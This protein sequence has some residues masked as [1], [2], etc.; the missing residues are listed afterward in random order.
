MHRCKYLLS[1]LAALSAST[2]LAQPVP[3]AE[4][5][6]VLDM[7]TI[8]GT[9]LATEVMNSP[10][11]IT[12]LEG[13][14]L[15]RAGPASVAA[16]LRD[17]P[18][19]HISEEGIER[20]TIR[21]ESARR[22]AILVDGQKLTDH[23]DYGQPVLVDPTTI[24]RIEVLRGSSSVVSG[25][26]AIGGVVNIITKKGADRPFALTGTAGWFSAPD[27]YRASVT[28]SGSLEAGAGM[29]DYRLSAGRMEHGDRRSPDGRLIPSDI[30]DKS[31]SA[32]LGYRLNDH[33]FGL[34]AQRYDVAANVYVDT[35][36]PITETYRRNPDFT[37]NLPKRELNKLSAFYEGRNLTPWLDQLN[38]D[39]YRQ[40]VDRLFHTHASLGPLPLM[41]L[42]TDSDDRQLTWGAQMRAQ[43]RLSDRS[44]TMVG[45]EYEDD[46]LTSDKLTLLPMSVTPA[47]RH[48]RAKITTFSIFAQHEIDLRPDLTFNLGGRWYDVSAK[49][50]AS[51]TNGAPNPLSANSDSLAMVSAGL[52]WTPAEDLA[53]RANVSQ[54]YIYPTLS[55]L[56]MQTYADSSYIIGNSGLSPERSTTFELGSR[57]D[58]GDLTLDATLFYSDARDYIGKTLVET[59]NIYQYHNIDR[60][61]TWGLELHAQHHLADHGLTPYVTAALMRRELRYDGFHTTDSG[62]SRIAGRIGLRKDWQMGD[63]WGDID[64]FLRA[65]S[66][67]RLRNEQGALVDAVPGYGTLNLRAEANFSYDISLAVELNNLTNRSY[68]PFDQTP[69]AERSINVFLTRAF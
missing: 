26:R 46:R 52:V 56:F 29:L 6:L 50:R 36:D 13:E 8:I 32:H 41:R 18:G 59:P 3:D 7:I 33:Y 53:F 5:T 11:S 9:G 66:K 1:L 65:E 54:G 24:E 61:R 64:L 22:I 48:D 60:A 44:R 37:I 49:H 19:V 51:L 2:A 63:I 17:V 4:T 43:M 42:Q 14:A 39:I 67:A 40:T 23:T 10:A 35:F 25:S 55:Q 16:M 62:T 58:R 20:I 31:L 30:E 38:V 57:L 27:G 68:K 47:I 45:L 21:G 28:A 69:G 34:R 15:R 12:V